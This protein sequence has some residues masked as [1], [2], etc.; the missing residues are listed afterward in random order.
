M[1]LEKDISDFRI[2]GFAPNTGVV[3]SGT[4]VVNSA[5]VVKLGSDVSI[6][7]G[8]ISV[9]YLAG[10]GLILVPGVSYIFG[11]SVNCH[12]MS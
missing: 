1:K 2:Q 5:T 9:Q 11:T 3:L 7:I 6:S 12:T 4:V 10:E 8:G